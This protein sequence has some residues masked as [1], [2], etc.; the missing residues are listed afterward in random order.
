MTADALRRVY[1]QGWITRESAEQFN[2][3]ECHD[4]AL[5]AVARHVAQAQRDMEPTR[6][7]INAG[8]DQD[9]YYETETHYTICI[10]HYA[11]YIYRAMQRAAP[12]V[13]DPEGG[14]DG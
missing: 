6:E 9:I 14:S 10:G 5:L 2:G 4:A 13:T 3:Y 8:G 12:L 7:M 11:E 1:E